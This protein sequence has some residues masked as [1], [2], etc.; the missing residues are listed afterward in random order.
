MRVDFLE[1]SSVLR[2]SEKA[3]AALSRRLLQRFL[4]EVLSIRKHDLNAEIAEVVTGNQF[5]RYICQAL[6]AVRVIGNFAAHPIKDKTTEAITDVEE[7]EAEW[8]LDT[9]QDLFEFYYLATV[10]FDDRKAALNAKL[11]KAGKPL[12]S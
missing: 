8:L 12:L 9:L 6:Q 3:S 4:H 10:R 2:Y 1:A 5:P 7:G 11:T